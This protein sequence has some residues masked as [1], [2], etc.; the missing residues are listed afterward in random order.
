MYDIAVIVAI[1][2]VYGHLHHLWI[3]VNLC[4]SENVGLVA[5]NRQNL[6][7]RVLETH[8]IT[9]SIIFYVHV[10]CAPLK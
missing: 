7:L 6:K 10:F 8:Y 4:T 5:P 9:V 2:K 3:I 1:R